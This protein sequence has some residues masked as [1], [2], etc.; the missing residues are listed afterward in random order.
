MAI[1][2]FSPKRSCLVEKLFSFLHAASTTGQLC[3]I[4]KQVAPAH[5]IGM[6][7]FFR[8][9]RPQ[10]D[11][12][13]TCQGANNQPSLLPCLSQLNPPTC[14]KSSRANSPVGVFER[15][16]DMWHA[17]DNI[18]ELDD[19]WV[20]HSLLLTQNWWVANCSAD[21]GSE[22]RTGSQSGRGCHTPSEPELRS[23]LVLRQSH[24]LKLKSKQSNKQ[25]RE[26]GLQAAAPATASRNRTRYWHA[27]HVLVWTWELSF[28]WW[29]CGCPTIHLQSHHVQYEAQQNIVP[30]LSWQL[31]VRTTVEKYQG[32]R[33]GAIRTSS[34]VI[35]SDELLCWWYNHN[36]VV[37]YLVYFDQVSCSM[38]LWEDVAHNNTTQAKLTTALL[39]HAHIHNGAYRAHIIT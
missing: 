9:C 33:A 30:H 21:I 4:V 7:F 31:V 1:Q 14:P 16:D 34:F 13:R 26:I 37:L 36:A 23:P 20:P 12:S 11:S 3:K 6:R 17:M 2:H 25:Q 35:W 22:E 5:T 27:S 28:R 19:I 8:S 32:R 18:H 38:K 15:Q 29:P 24:S 39:P 10:V